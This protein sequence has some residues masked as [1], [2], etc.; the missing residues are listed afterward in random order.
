MCC[1][2][3]TKAVI[4]FFYKN[5]GAGDGAE[6]PVVAGVRRPALRGT[7]M[8]AGAAAGS[9]AG[10]A[11]PTHG[12]VPQQGSKAAAQERPRATVPRSPRLGPQTRKRA[13]EAEAQPGGGQPPYAAPVWTHG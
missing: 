11:L 3:A 12:K 9:A 8:M 4:H 7:K 2:A 1:I 10:G 13:A 5:A 6:D